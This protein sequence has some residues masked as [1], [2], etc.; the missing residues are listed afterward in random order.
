MQEDEIGLRRAAGQDV[1]VQCSRCGRP[2]PERQATPA[3]AD[4]LVDDTGY[5]VLCPTCREE[6]AD[7]E[8]DLTLATE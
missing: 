5:D 7:G 6:L 8:Q 2:I 1:Y 3:P 4:A